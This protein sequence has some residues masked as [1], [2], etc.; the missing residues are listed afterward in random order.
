MTEQEAIKALT[1]LKTACTN[2]SDTVKALDTAIKAL[3]EIKSIVKLEPWKS[4]GRIRI[5]RNQRK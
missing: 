3:I 5:S 4:A 2:K 1:Y